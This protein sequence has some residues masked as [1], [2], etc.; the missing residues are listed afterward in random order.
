MNCNVTS[1]L[2]YDSKA[3]NPEPKG[4]D[5]FNPFDDF[6]LVP[7]DGLKQYSEADHTVTLDMKM[8][9]LGDGAN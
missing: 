8:D 2:V 3:E 7:Q 5:E 4:V 1:W 6:T 9:N